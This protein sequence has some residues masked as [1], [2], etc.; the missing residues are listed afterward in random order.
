[1]QLKESTTGSGGGTGAATGELSKDVAAKKEGGGTN[2]VDQSQK[3]GDTN[4]STT[5]NSVAQSKPG[6]RPQNAA[7]S[8][9]MP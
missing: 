1:M 7:A 2:V 3:M 4:V 8:A 9:F 5:N 6:A